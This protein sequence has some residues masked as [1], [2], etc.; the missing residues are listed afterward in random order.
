MTQ[1]NTTAANT[2]AHTTEIL[3]SI[4]KSELKFL[5]VALLADKTR[6]QM[7]N[8]I[9]R[10]CDKLNQ[11]VIASSDAHRLHVVTLGKHYATVDIL[12]DVCF[13]VD[14]NA[15][16]RQMTAHKCGGV[17]IL[18]RISASGEFINAD[19]I[20]TGVPAFHGVV[21]PD[22]NKYPNINNVLIGNLPNN[23]MGLKGAFNGHY[24]ADACTHLCGSKRETDTHRVTFWQETELRPCVVLD[25][26]RQLGNNEMYYGRKFALIMPMQNF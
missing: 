17:S 6:P 23:H 16:L 9:V 24:V 8:A 10:Y 3:D 2:G 20:G 7:E 11:F 22:D 5:Q 18:V 1:V 15:L 25:S 26:T 13:Q 14:V 19:I 21:I 4:T 12:N